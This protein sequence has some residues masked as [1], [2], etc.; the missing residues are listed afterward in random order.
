MM[1]E[2]LGE[3]IHPNFTET[4]EDIYYLKSEVDR[5]IQRLKEVIEQLKEEN[6]RLGDTI[7]TMLMKDVKRITIKDLSNMIPRTKVRGF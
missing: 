6:E 2:Y 5:E 3:A 7:N 1:N 4:D